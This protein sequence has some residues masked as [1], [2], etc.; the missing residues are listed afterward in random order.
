MYLLFGVLR[1]GP[2]RVALLPQELTG[3]QEWLG[4]LKL[5][6]LK[7]GNTHGQAGQQENNIRIC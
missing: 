5:P 3:A 2:G 6:P 1:V 4:V 7:Q